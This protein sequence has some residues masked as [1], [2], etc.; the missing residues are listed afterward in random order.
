MVNS[1]SENKQDKWI[2]L[3][4]TLAIHGALILLFIYIA[5]TTPLPPFPEAPSPGIEINFGNLTEGTGNTEANDKGDIVSE[6]NEAKTQP[7]E[8]SPSVSEQ[9]EEIVTSEAENTITINK[10]KT[11]K[12]EKPK[13]I[14]EQKEVI[15]QPSNDLQNALNKL[16]NKKNTGSGGDGS[17]GNAGNA[18]DPNGTPDGTG[19][20]GGGG[21]G[22]AYTLKGR[23]ILK[24]PDIVDDSQEEGKVVVEI[25]VDET[26]K[27]V[28]AIPGERGS[29]T[30]SAILYAKAR[31]AALSAK[32]NP[33]SDGMQ[34]QR[35]TLTFVFIL[36]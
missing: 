7:Q 27:V 33:S 29:T 18:G 32:F 24:R 11:K 3:L 26:G 35:G 5:F 12:V 19:P 22:F 23:K 28:K 16:K 21:K 9:A 31:Q 15:P 6:I 14:T 36:N 1:S 25:I 4:A 34:E 17:S 30:T 8:T 10:N 20:G 2:A 13:E